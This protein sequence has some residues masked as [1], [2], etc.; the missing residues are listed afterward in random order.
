[1]W[2]SFQMPSRSGDA[3]RAGRR[4]FREDEPAPPTA[5]L[6]DDQVQS[7]RSRRYWSMH[8]GDSN[9][10]GNVRSRMDIGEKR[11][12][13]A[14]RFVGACL[15]ARVAARCAACAASARVVPFARLPACAWPRASRIARP[16][17]TRNLTP[18][19]HAARIGKAAPKPPPHT[20]RTSGSPARP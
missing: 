3:L 13:I 6:P 2:S 18:H 16:R 4:S 9:A 15:G 5:R 8:I 17:R 1:M 12:V 14:V 20:L 7:W 19:R 10:V 11:S